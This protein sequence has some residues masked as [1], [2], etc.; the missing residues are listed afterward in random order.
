MTTSQREQI[1]VKIFENWL[2]SLGKMGVLV[3]PAEKE[4]FARF[5][6]L[7]RP[8]T[9]VEALELL[10]KEYPNR[11]VMIEKAQANLRLS[12]DNITILP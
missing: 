8:K 12:K 2:N 7:K 3:G 5:I 1:S 10:K 4:K 9:R 6:I 11:I